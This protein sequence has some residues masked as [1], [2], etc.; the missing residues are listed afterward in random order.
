MKS[1]YF[2]MPLLLVTVMSCLAQQKSNDLNNNNWLIGTWVRQNN[3]PGSESY[4]IWNQGSHSLNGLGF[5]MRQGDT[6]FVEY[7]KLLVKDGK[8]F[9]VA[10]VAHN[11]APTYFEVTSLKENGFTCENSAHDFPKKIEYLLEGNT[12]TATISGDGKSI[13]FVFKKKE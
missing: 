12:L 11:P 10:E 1:N 6:V 7:L 13:P 8:K 2:I 9:Y 5:T 4:E 3:S